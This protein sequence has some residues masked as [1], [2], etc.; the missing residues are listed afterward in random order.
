MRKKW[1][2][3]EIW[4]GTSVIL[5]LGVIGAARGMEVIFHL[6]PCELCLTQRGVYWVAAGL[7]TLGLC[8]SRLPISIQF[9]RLVCWGL[10]TLFIF[11]TALAAYHTGVEWKWW[12]GP[13]ACTGG[14]AHVTSADIAAYLSGPHHLVRCDE[15][16][17]RFLGLSLAGWNVPLGLSLTAASIFFAVHRGGSRYGPRRIG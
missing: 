10:A 6:I 4:I 3:Q 16:D 8:V 2:L 17:W 11:E 14:G 5:C 9:S 1:N 7:A 12:P 13:S 15:P